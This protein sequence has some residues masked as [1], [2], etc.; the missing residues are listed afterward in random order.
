MRTEER[1]MSTRP[2]AIPDDASRRLLHAAEILSWLVVGALMLFLG[3]RH[4]LGRS[5]R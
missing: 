1:T 2:A 5:T 3:G 4:A